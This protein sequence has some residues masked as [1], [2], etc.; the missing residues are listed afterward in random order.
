MTIGES[1][2][3]AI[4][5]LRRLDFNWSN[6]LISDEEYARQLCDLMD[7]E[8]M[9]DKFRELA[10]ENRDLRQRAETAEARL[11]DMR[12]GRAIDNDEGAEIIIDLRRQLETAETARAHL[13]FA[14]RHQAEANEAAKW[15]DAGFCP[16]CHADELRQST[17][18]YDDE[19]NLSVI[20]YRCGACGAL[21][22]GDVNEWVRLVKRLEA[23]EQ[24]LMVYRVLLTG[25][26]MAAAYASGLPPTLEPFANAYFTELFQVALDSG[27]FAEAG[28]GTTGILAAAEQLHVKF[29]FAEE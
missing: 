15:Q 25:A 3:K 24:Q 17:D 19:L 16:H 20:V 27:S 29:P 26:M 28:C 13:A 11:A 4:D 12:D 14:L 7:Y 23:A 18:L 10:K 1:L 6:N 8:E 22:A 9:A 21:W 2:Q 5:D